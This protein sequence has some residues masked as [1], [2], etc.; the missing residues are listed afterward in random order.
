VL[1]ARSVI[2]ATVAIAIVSILATVFELT[3]TPDSGGRA[4]DSFGT[5]AYGQR[6]LFELLEELNVPV[7]RSLVPPTGV[8]HRDVCLVIWNPDPA[9]VELEPGYLESVGRWVREGGIVVVAPAKRSAEPEYRRA[10]RQGYPGYRELSALE[11]L[12]LDSVSLTTVEEADAKSQGQP[13]TGWFPKAEKE[14]S[15]WVDSLMHNRPPPPQSV[16]TSATGDLAD[17]DPLIGFV[18]V[19]LTGLQVIDPA[20]TATATG[21]VV[22]RPDLSNEHTLV[23]LFRVGRGVVLVVADPHV[24]LNYAI[25]KQDNA[26]LAAHLL[27]HFGRPVVFDEFYHG[28]TVRGNPYWLLTRHPYG[29]AALLVFLVS[30]LWVWR[31][32]VHLGPPLVER[33]TRRRTVAEYVEAVA[34]M[35]HR[36]NCRSFVLGEVRDGIVWALRKRLHLGPKQENV[37]DVARALARRNPRQAER[38]REA[39]GGVDQLLRE[40][41]MPKEKTVI[42][43]A[44]KVTQ[45]LKT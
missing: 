42:E 13:T 28:L 1:T 40:E 25:A 17:L 33:L 39:V 35:F 31:N 7:E 44:R 10:M 14:E 30:A 3:R 4:H 19:P 37:D 15:G 22:C 6:A 20:S 27:A 32:W 26:I 18:E 43:A 2:I 38:L 11:A 21:R 8:L 23:A 45:C 9:L 12:G 16:V 5:V 34:N 24:L 36:S 29:L 41:Y